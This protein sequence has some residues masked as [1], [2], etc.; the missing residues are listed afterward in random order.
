MIPVW[1]LAIWAN[2]APRII[3]YG[4]VA[5]FAGFAWW[6]VSGHYEAKGAAEA[7]RAC[8]AEKR[9]AADAHAVKVATLEDQLS[10]LRVA[11]DT[12]SSEDESKIAELQAALAKGQN[13]KGKGGWSKDT[14]KR[15][16]F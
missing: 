7:V 5:L 16:G 12:K 4:I 1:A 13:N 15:L 6:Q 9:A 2:Y 11:H 3:S 10:R 8:N 14:A